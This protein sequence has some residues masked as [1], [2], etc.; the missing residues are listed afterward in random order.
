MDAKN[1]TNVYSTHKKMFRI[2]IVLFMLLLLLYSVFALYVSMTLDSVIKKAMN[3][4]PYDDT[5]AGI[6]SEEEY[7]F[8]NPRQPES[9]EGISIETERT[10]YPPF[11]LPFLTDANYVFSYTV[12]NRIT[13]EVVYGTSQ[14]HVTI[15]LS[16]QSFPVYITEVEVAP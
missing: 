6:I 13:N 16:Y 11:V 15:R 5:I 12:T 1:I 10:N 14:G 2:I 4:E 3:D 7:G 8:L 9:E